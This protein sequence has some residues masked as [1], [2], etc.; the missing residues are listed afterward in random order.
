MK[1]FS[2]KTIDHFLKLANEI[3]RVDYNAWKRVDELP[4]D[5]SRP[6]LPAG[7][8]LIA[9][10]WLE[11]FIVRTADDRVLVSFGVE[12][13][14]TTLPELVN[15]E[16]VLRVIDLATFE[17]NENEEYTVVDMNDKSNGWMG[18]GDLEAFLLNVIGIPGEFGGMEL[19]T[20]DLARKFP[21]A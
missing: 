7:T 12:S 11:G 14:D 6:E 4:L 19:V 18:T 1:N 20:E 9:N 15:D 5:Y 10:G 3:P 2:Q 16:N 17:F 13:T 8:Q 21:L